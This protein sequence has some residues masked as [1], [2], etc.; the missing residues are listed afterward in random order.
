[1]DM[2]AEG[3]AM[4]AHF[5]RDGIYTDKPMAVI[6]EY[7]CNAIDEHRK[8]CPDLPVEVHL[9]TTDNP[10]FRVRDFALGLDR[11]TLFKVYGKLFKSTKTGEN[12]SIGG[13]GIGSKAG[14][15]Y[16]SQFFVDSVHEGRKTVIA[17]VLENNEHGISMGKMN[18]MHEGDSDDISGVEVKVPVK[19]S[20]IHVFHTAFKRFMYFCDFPIDVISHRD[21]EY[22]TF[23]DEIH[24]SVGN[25]HYIKKSSMDIRGSYVKVGDVCYKAD[26]L[27]MGKYVSGWGSLLV[28]DVPIGEVSIAPSREQIEFNA[29]TKH[30]LATQLEAFEKEA[31]KMVEREMESAKTVIEAV[32]IYQEATRYSIGE[33][34]L[35]WN[36]EEAPKKFPFPKMDWDDKEK[37][38]KTSWGYAFY[39]LRGDQVD[40]PRKKISKVSVI[41]VDTEYFFVHIGQQVPRTKIRYWSEHNNYPYEVAVLSFQNE[42]MWEEWNKENGLTET[43]GVTVVMSEDVDVP[44]GYYSANV[45]GCYNR[46]LPYFRKWGNGMSKRMIDQSLMDALAEQDEVIYV[47]VKGKH[48]D[49]D[50]AVLSE[51]QKAVDNDIQVWGIPAS[52]RKLCKI[53]NFVHFSE[54]KKGQQEEAAEL[55]IVKYA[56]YEAWRKLDRQGVFSPI[57]KIEKYADYLPDGS[58]L[59][60][61]LEIKRKFSDTI[62]C[63]TDNSFQW[64]MRWKECED[65]Q[66]R[67]TKLIKQKWEKVKGTDEFT[68]LNCINPENAG[69]D[70]ELLDKLFSIF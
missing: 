37:L 18:I 44:R 67:F 36:G 27:N 47:L 7:I 8:H 5:L 69:G 12:E 41:D 28:L 15:A 13:F 11:D 53:E 29:E 68:I 19:P 70:K 10:F 40:N 52:L 49:D 9:P 51:V 39:N 17:A 55:E 42:E 50:N 45:A 34:K 38:E 60:N 2:D 58:P 24:D 21:K 3:M 35:L 65:L 20:D 33:H 32:R 25:F 48:L 54:W 61:A 26:D 1:M 23:K 59:H 16:A 30:Y 63:P 62:P 66:G 46:Y 31:V 4:A 6:R 64:A 14:H 56:K 57:G 43:S 22:K